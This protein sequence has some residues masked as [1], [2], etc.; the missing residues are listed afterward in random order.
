MIRHEMIS[1]VRYTCKNYC[2]TVI[3]NRIVLYRVVLAVPYRN[4]LIVS[5]HTV[6]QRTNRT[7][8][9]R[10]APH[11]PLCFALLPREPK[12]SISQKKKLEVTSPA[13]VV[14]NAFLD[15]S[16]L[17]KEGLS[18]LLWNFFWRDAL[19]RR[20]LDVLFVINS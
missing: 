3:T 7:V 13:I 8:S 9:N 4:V 11:L 15:S 20:Y 18:G 6:L 14:L 10:I 19:I 16:G 17:P 12:V 5:F 2:L 1:K